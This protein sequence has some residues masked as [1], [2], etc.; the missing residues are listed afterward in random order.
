[1]DG[2]VP[3]R[4][5]R[6]KHTPAANGSKWIWPSTRWAI[7]HR[8]GFVCVY[9]LRDEQLTLDHI[10][11]VEGSGQNNA[12]ANLVTTCN[13]CN[14]SKKSMSMR[15]W[16]ARLRDRGLD[17]KTIQL[18]I[19]RQCRRRLVRSMGIALVAIASLDLEIPGLQEVLGGR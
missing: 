9:C 11:S 2:S 16:L 12:P 15:A 19:R 1:M 6:S 3:S 5:R 4:K 8:D 18:R 7:Y 17:T 13:P 10:R 14:S